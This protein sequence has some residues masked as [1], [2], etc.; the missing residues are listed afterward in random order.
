[1]TLGVPGTAWVTLGVLG[2]VWVTLGVP[3]TVWVCRDDSG[4]AGITLIGPGTAGMTLMGQERTV[5]SLI[6]TQDLQNA[7]G[8][9][10][11]FRFQ[12]TYLG[13]SRNL[14]C[15]LVCLSGY[16]YGRSTLISL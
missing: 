9:F 15:L 3:G 10:L 12:G 5:R 8:Y 14:V 2:T 4:C 11:Q 7:L 13:L 6:E 16:L 1:M